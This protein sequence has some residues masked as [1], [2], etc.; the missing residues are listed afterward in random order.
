VRRAVV[1]AAMGNCVEWYDFGVY[2]YVAGTVGAV[3]FPSG[4]DT[5]RLLAVFGV[6]AVSFLVR[7]FGGMFFGPL[8]DKIGRQKVLVGTLLLMSASTVSIGLLPGYATIGIAAPILLLII[9]MLQGFSTGG[10][11]GGAATFIAE[12]APDKR[13]GFLCSWLEFGTLGGYVLGAGSAAGLTAILSDD[14]MSSWGWR[15]PFLVGGPLG[16]IG[17]YLR[18]RLEDTPAFQDL[19]GHQEVSKSPLR[20]TL[21]QNR[22]PL[23]ICVGIVIGLGVADYAILTF[24]PTYLTETLKMDGGTSLLLTVGVMM[25]MMLLIPL[26]GALS[27]RIGRRPIQLAGAFGL[28][29]TPIPALLLIQQR[30]PFAIIG[31]MALMGVFLVCFL[32]TIPSTLPSLFPTAVRY[33]AFAISYNVSVSVFGGTTPLVIEFLTARTGNEFVP[34]FYVMAAMLVAVVPIMLAPESAGKPLPGGHEVVPPAP[35]LPAVGVPRHQAP[36]VSRRSRH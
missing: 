30:G 29:V 4:N 19:K 27:D 3:F 23:L 8:G 20:E 28:F 22:R 10:E 21:V 25:I 12:Y 13:R 15:V 1:A 24:M 7:P 35:R 26:T 31:G 17:L 18:Y 14:A 11:Y 6:V 16:L 32:G 5:V 36:H 33:A 2:S 34:A 9:R